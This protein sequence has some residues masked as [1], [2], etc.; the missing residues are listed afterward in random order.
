MKPRVLVVDDDPSIRSTVSV[1]LEH[2]G[3]SVTGAAD[4]AE[5]LEQL[6]AG[7]RGILLMDV[8]MPRMDGWETIRA[9]IDEDLLR[10]NLLCMLTVVRAPGGA[11]EGLEGYVLDY[12]PKP[13]DATQLVAMVNNAADCLTV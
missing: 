5:C 12:L 2:H 1:V 11:A 6:R 7:F 4:G 9:I 8:M 13:F 3:Y 10:D